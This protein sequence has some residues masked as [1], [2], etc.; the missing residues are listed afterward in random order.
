[1]KLIGRPFGLSSHRFAVSRG[2][3]EMDQIDMPLA[4]VLGI[5]VGYAIRAAIS[6]VRRQRAYLWRRENA[7]R[8]A[9]IH[10]NLLRPSV[11]TSEPS[12]AASESWPAIEKRI[13]SAI[14]RR[15]VS[16]GWRRRFEDPISLPRGRQLFTLK[17]AADY[18]TR[19]PKAE[20]E[21]PH[22]QAAV[23]ALIMAA[24]DR[25]PLLHA[26]VGMLRVLNRHVERVFNPDRKDHHW[27]RRKLKRGEWSPSRRRARHDGFD[28]IVE[29]GR[30]EH[31]RPDAGFEHHLEWCSFNEMNTRAD[32]VRASKPRNRRHLDDVDLHSVRSPVSRSP[33]AAGNIQAVEIRTARIKQRIG[34]LQVWT[35]TKLAIGRWSVECRLLTHSESLV[36]LISRTVPGVPDQQ[37]RSMSAKAWLF[38]VPCIGYAAPPFGFG[39]EP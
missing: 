29:F 37:P 20:H 35:L 22:W 5:A 23:E 6:S 15:L 1:V 14:A 17:D 30:L 36:R 24:E 3:S 31:I 8:A 18:I 2:G 11:P 27:G 16:R 10:L 9:E 4:F 28:H 25:A 21:T 19:L 34:I 33:A 12:T 38:P 39:S 32:V 13:G 7:R 26:R